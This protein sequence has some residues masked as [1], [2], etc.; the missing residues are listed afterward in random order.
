MPVRT[1]AKVAG[2]VTAAQGLGQSIGF[3]IAGDVTDAGERSR[4][5]DPV[6]LGSVLGQHHHFE[7]FLDLE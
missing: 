1:T 6:D 2:P 3:R 4:Q 5:A 7:P